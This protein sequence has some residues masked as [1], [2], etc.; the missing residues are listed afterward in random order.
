MSDWAA[1][2]GAG[3]RFEWGP[4]GADRL[5]AAAASGRQLAAMGFVEDM[6][7]ATAKDTCAV[8]PVR[9]GDGAFALG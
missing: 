6:A 1:Q 4:A 7:I 9:D 2:S 3:V 8:V 5:V